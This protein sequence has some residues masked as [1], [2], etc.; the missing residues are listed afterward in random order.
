MYQ[1]REVEGSELTSF[2]S[3]ITF[4]TGNR[5]QCICNNCFQ[6]YRL[7]PGQNKHFGLQPLPGMV[8]NSKLLLICQLSDLFPDQYMNMPVPSMW[9]GLL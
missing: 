4:H 2:L 8:I 7:F 5:L 9:V 3:K 6:L 1:L